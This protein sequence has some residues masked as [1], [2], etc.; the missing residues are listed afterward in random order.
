MEKLYTEADM[1]KAFL[2]GVGSVFYDNEE[3]RYV[4]SFK[5]ENEWFNHFSG[6]ETWWEVYIIYEDES[7][8]TIESF[9]TEAEALHYI[10]L[11]QSANPDDKLG[12]DEWSENRKIK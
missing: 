10:A 12:W 9:D 11:H 8:E 4:Y 7:T 5:D 2:D 3:E 6:K 1:K